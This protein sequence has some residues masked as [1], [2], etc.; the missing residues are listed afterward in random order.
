MNYTEKAI[1]KK[2]LKQLIKYEIEQHGNS[3][4]LNH[5]D[6]SNVINMAGLFY[7]FHEFNGD[8]SGWDVSRVEDM[9]EMFS[10]SNF[11]G[12]ISRWNVSKV[13]DMFSMFED[14]EFNGDISN[15]DVKNVLNMNYI[16]Y[17]AKFINDLSN[18][19]P[20]KVD[21]MSFV[22]RGAKCPQPYWA[23]YY[24]LEDRKVAI[25]NYIEKKNLNEKLTHNLDSD[26]K[27]ISKKVK[28]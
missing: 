16:F 10:A 12:D 26:I 17:N 13:I 2:H 9:T 8:I 25:D 6:I 24:D 4:D 21:E 22:F 19:A 1:D 15:W 20:Y 18:W 27:T 23:G 11:N 7:D 3:C 28:L 14:S 5:I